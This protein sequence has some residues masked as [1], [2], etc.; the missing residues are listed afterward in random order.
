M[1]IRVV[2]T[3]LI[4]LLKPILM[5]VLLA[6]P[7]PMAVAGEPAKLTDYFPPPESKGG[8]RTLLPEKGPPDAAQ[9]ARI[10][11]VAGVDWDKLAEAWKH[12]LRADGS[13][14]LLV[15]RRG[16]I[17]GEWYKDRDRYKTSS[18]WS[19][20][21]AYIS[22][23]IGLMIDDSAQGKLKDGKKLS[24]DT[25]VYNADW[26][27]E[28]LPLSDPRKAGI[29]LRQLLTMTS[30]HRARRRQDRRGAKREMEE[31]GRRR[32]V[33]TGPRH[34]GGFAVGQAH[35]RA[36]FRLQLQQPEFAASGPHIQPGRRARPR[37]GH[38]GARL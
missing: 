18:F 32:L 19:S 13:T 36:R 7:L 35:G 28:G 24:L 2:Q 26:L 31:G 20:T 10:R 27:P 30:G 11:A 34:G 16:H 1:K 8:W 5:T 38:E 23:G 9:K 12:N 14:G 22:T 37:C 4:F 21:K 17:V 6:L 29:T 3:A 33:R 15:I 25:K